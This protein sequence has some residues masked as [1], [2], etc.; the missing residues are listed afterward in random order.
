MHIEVVVR[1][2]EQM[3]DGYCGF[4]LARQYE[5]QGVQKHDGQQRERDDKHRFSRGA[6]S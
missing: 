5:L 1:E 3:M 4:L 6:L 2:V